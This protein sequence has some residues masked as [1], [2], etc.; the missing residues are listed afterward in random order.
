MV[1]TGQ[2]AQ[3]LPFVHAVFEGFAPVDE[4]DRHFVI[5]L[6]PQ[7]SVAIDIY[8]LPREPATA[9]ELRQ[10]FLHYFAQM[11]TLA[12][13]NHDLAG[14]GHAAIVPAPPHLLARKKKSEAPNEG[15]FPVQE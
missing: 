11:T 9:R 7:F 13:V 4:H 3:K 5:E 15:L 14:F 6:P 8:F 2:L 12:R 10:A 1:L